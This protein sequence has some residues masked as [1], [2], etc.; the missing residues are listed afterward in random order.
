MFGT[1]ANVGLRCQCPGFEHSGERW[2]TETFRE[3]AAGGAQIEGG[4]AMDVCTYQELGM[5]MKDEDADEFGLPGSAEE[6]PL[7]LRLQDLRLQDALGLLGESSEEETEPAPLPPRQVEPAPAPAPALDPEPEPEPPQPQPDPPAAPTSDDKGEAPQPQVVPAASGETDA[8]VTPLGRQRATTFQRELVPPQAASSLQSTNSALS[9]Q[10]TAKDRHL[11][12]YMPSQWK[13]PSESDPCPVEIIELVAQETATGKELVARA[14]QKYNTEVAPSPDVMLSDEPSQFELRV[15]SPDAEGGQMEF[16]FQL[17]LAEM[18]DDVRELV[19]RP[20]SKGKTESGS[21]YIQVDVEE[22][23]RMGACTQTIAAPRSETFAWVLSHI[24]KKLQQPMPEDRY[25][26]ITFNYA[27]EE[28]SLAMGECVD[29]LR[30]GGGVSPQGRDPAAMPSIHRVT[31]RQIRMADDPDRPSSR[32][33]VLRAPSATQVAAAA[34][35]SV[36]RASMAARAGVMMSDVVASQYKEY[37]VW[38]LPGRYVHECGMS[39]ASSAV[40]CI[41]S[42]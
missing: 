28:E 31:L 32:R 10:V 26:F 4:A 5:L 34:S 21:L 35:T 33:S 41:T 22:T 30:L 40:A 2:L 13:V 36:A 7:D 14:L 6:H 11:L 9:R 42:T 27:G 29:S 18:G 8:A 19:L 25:E 39:F 12:V 23:E 3:A 1:I 24:G 37:Q 38:R 20:L 15:G 16:P 17:K